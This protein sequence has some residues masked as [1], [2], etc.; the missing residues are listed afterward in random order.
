M[1]DGE[2]KTKLIPSRRRWLDLAIMLVLMFGIGAL[3]PFGTV[4]PYGMQIL[5]ILVGVIYAWIRGEIIW[6]SVIAFVVMGLCG[7]NTVAGVVS[8]AFGNGSVIQVICALLFCYAIQSTGLL[9]VIASWILSRK[10]A[11]KSLWSLAFAFFL[12]ATVGAIILGGG[13]PVVILLWTVFY[14]VCDQMC[15]KPY[16]K[17]PTL[18]MIG[19]GIC[20]D[21]G[22]IVMPYNPWLAICNGMFSSV[23]G[24]LTFNMGLYIAFMLILNVAILFAVTFVFWLIGRNIDYSEICVPMKETKL[25]K[26]DK[27]MALYL[28]I[29]LALLVLPGVLPG[30]NP[31]FD[32]LRKIGLSGMFLLVPVF[33]M[34]VTYEGENLYDI[35]KALKEGVAWD[36]V[37]LIACALTLGSALTSKDTG[38]AAWLGSTVSSLLAGQSIAMVMIIMIAAVVVLTNAI[39]N[40]VVATIMLPLGVTIITAMGGNPTLF[41]MFVVVLSLQGIVMPSGSIVGALLHGNSKWL[42]PSMIYKYTIIG[43]LAVL[44][45][46]TICIPLGNM[47][48]G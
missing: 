6:S 25:T 33:Y 21:S 19:I 10:F 3:P 4:T 46:S 20:A 1:A 31:V 8:G 15:I 41:A 7:S 35:G 12:A 48:I 28:M 13:F 45:V 30:G 22:S 36:T 42:K 44:A 26:R 47:L 38:I 40:G 24:G 23:S 2:G 34:M 18:V 14:D 5:G 27:R 43:E 9:D 29:A 16:E 39:N 37:V 17:Y 11:R 32:V